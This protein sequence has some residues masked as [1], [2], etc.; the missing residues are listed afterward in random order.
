MT[1]REQLEAKFLAQAKVEHNSI[2]EE[3][4]YRILEDRM[5]KICDRCIEKR[6]LVREFNMFNIPTKNADIFINWYLHSNSRFPIN[7]VKAALFLHS[8]PE[9]LNDHRID[10]F[11]KF[12]DFDPRPA[13]V[14]PATTPP[15]TETYEEYLLKCAKYKKDLPTCKTTWCFAKQEDTVNYVSDC[16]SLW[17][18]DNFYSAYNSQECISVRG[19]SSES[20][21]EL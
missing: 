6:S 20:G 4:L 18:N 5:E 19:E 12:G 3:L 17:C 2:P 8:P 15:T 13:E 14:P 1:L 10:S 11:I 16:K 9:V 7:E 21:V